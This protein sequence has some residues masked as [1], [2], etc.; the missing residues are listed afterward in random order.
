[1][2]AEPAVTVVVVPRERFSAAARC[3]DAL[4]ERTPEPHRLVVVDGRSPPAVAA[5][6][7]ARAAERGF[8]LVRE[9]RYLSPNEA[10][11][12][13]ARGVRTEYIAFVD[14]DCLVQPGWLG[15]LLAAADAS[16]ASAAA[17]LILH[18]EPEHGI[19]HA[20]G[21]EV[22]AETVGDLGV[23]RTHH[24]FLQPVASVALPGEAF[25][26]ECLEFHCM[27]VRTSALR[28]VGGLDEGLMSI[29]EHIDLSLRL[30][31]R[32]GTLLVV[33]EARVAYLEPA[34]LAGSDLGYFLLRW[35]DDWARRSVARF[36]ATW[37][38]GPDARTQLRWV[39]RQRM[40]VL[41]RFGDF[42]PHKLETRGM[43]WVERVWSRTEWPLNRAWVRLAGQHR[44]ARP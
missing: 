3:L 28:A 24:G 42:L 10:R 19:V 33:P 18:G 5:H 38:K 40:L 7:R 9:E 20:A 14:N 8:T 29:S 36:H 44:E 31:A 34:D 21:G 35:S 43:R 6:L 4:L 22:S 41:R 12:L 30:R 2:S 16:G 15:P 37:G 26:T 25:A 39:R 11:N 27:L 17:P 13:G 32:G 1:M 23:D